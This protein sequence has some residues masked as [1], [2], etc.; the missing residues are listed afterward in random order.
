MLALLER[1]GGQR[2]VTRELD[3]TLR[4]SHGEQQAAKFLRSGLAF[5]GLAEEDL[6]SL[7]KNDQRKVAIAAL[8]RRRTTVPNEWIARALHL[9]H[10]SRVSRCWA[11]EAALSAELEKRC[12]EK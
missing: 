10:V 6:A 3:A 12:D 8:I 11:Q 5:C 2:G 9:G 4:Q 7:R 1:D